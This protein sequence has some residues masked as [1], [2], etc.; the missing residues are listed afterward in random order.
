MFGIEAVEIVLFLKQ[1]GL[2][3]VGASGLWGFIMLKKASYAKD[4]ENAEVFRNLA[5]RLLTPLGIGAL[6]AILAWITLFF[7][8]VTLVSGH[9]GIVIE[10]TKQAIAESTV[11]T[12]TLFMLL[13]VTSVIGFGMYRKNKEKFLEKLSTFY[14]AQLIIAAALTVPVWSSI[15]NKEQLFFIG[16]SVHSI[17]TIGTVIVLDFTFFFSESVDKIRKHLYLFLPNMSKAIWIGLG[18]EFLS[19][20]LI[21]SDAL[22]L[23]PK[24]FFMQTVIGIIILNGAFLAGPMNKKLISS[25]KGNK[26][27]KL[28]RGWVRIE[29]VS[30]V[31]SISSWGTITFLDFLKGLT[32]SYSQMALFYAGVLVFIYVCYAMLER[33]RPRL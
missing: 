33:V 2:A 29:G 5:E 13:A 8:D 12:G 25:V 31:I 27:E 10:P 7:I 14:L 4:R 20:S 24:F 26:V 1:L 15:L 23:T 30:G 28:S 22:L 3:V 11:V 6:V 9:E 18:I 17:L 21:F 32:A 16:H 19:V